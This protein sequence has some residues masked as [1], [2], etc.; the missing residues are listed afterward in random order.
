MMHRFLAPA[1]AELEEAV[2]LYEARRQGLGAEFAA[3]VQ[4][5]VGRI[6]QLP[7]PALEFL[8]VPPLPGRSFS[9]SVRRSRRGRRMYS[10]THST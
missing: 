1:R 8:Q 10:V 3:E 6:L 4:R 9:V 7:S 5:A 2:D